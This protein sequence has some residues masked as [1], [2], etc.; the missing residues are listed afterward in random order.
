MT[1]YFY[2]HLVTDVKFVQ[3]DSKIQQKKKKKIPISLTVRRG[4]E[5][6]PKVTHFS[7][8]PFQLLFLV[9]MLKIYKGPAFVNKPVG[10][11]FNYFSVLPHK[12]EKRT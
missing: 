11:S 7:S 12:N 5:S 8:F 10:L 6:S 2:L 1:F 3:T 9:H 4:S